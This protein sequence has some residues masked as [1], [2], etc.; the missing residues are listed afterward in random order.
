MKKLM[1]KKKY[2][3]IVYLFWIYAGGIIFVL[4]IFFVVIDAVYQSNIYMDAKNQTTTFCTSIQSAVESELNKMSSIATNVVYSDVIRD[5]VGLNQ[6]EGE[7]EV[8]QRRVLTF[9]CYKSM[10]L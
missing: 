10:L 8:S 9:L 7:L 1:R 2:S 3:Q 4:G 5:S 6:T